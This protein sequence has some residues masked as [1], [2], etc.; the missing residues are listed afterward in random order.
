MNLQ[1]TIVVTFYFKM[2]FILIDCLNLDC[3][4]L[5]IPGNFV[6]FHLFR[7]EAVVNSVRSFSMFHLI[8]ENLVIIIF[9]YK[10]TVIGSISFGFAIAN[11]IIAI[12]KYPKS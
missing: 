9:S 7:F 4:F 12:M 2:N 6:D 3:C 10:T 1:S 11:C 5:I 8:F